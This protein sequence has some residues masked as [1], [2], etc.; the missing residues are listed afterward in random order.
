MML[1]I[2]PTGMLKANFSSGSAR[3]LR[4]IQ[5]QSPPLSFVLSSEYI[6]AICSNSAPL[7]SFPVVLV[8]LG[9]RNDRVRLDVLAAHRSYNNLFH[10]LFLELA[11][12]VVLRLERFDKRVPVTTKRFLND[13]MDS[14]VH[15]V[16]G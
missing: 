8:D 1:L 11:Q 5:P 15:D 6:C 13:L 9:G 12:R 2:L 14:Q 10:L 3:V 4:S 16:I 7:A